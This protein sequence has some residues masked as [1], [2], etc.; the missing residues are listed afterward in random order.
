MISQDR[1]NFVLYCKYVNLTIV[2]KVLIFRNW[3]QQQHMIRKQMNSCYIHR[4]FRQQNGGQV[5]LGNHQI[6]L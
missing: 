5:V 1:N 4:Q 3:K 6:M 2:F